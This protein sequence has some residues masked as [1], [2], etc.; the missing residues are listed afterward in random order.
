MNRSSLAALVVALMLGSG[1]AGYLLGRPAD[2]VDT[3]TQT[4]AVPQPAPAAPSQP[5]TPAQP[6]TPTPATPVAAPTQPTPAPAPQTS[7]APV[8]LPQPPAAPDEPFAYRRFALDTSRAEG[9]A[10]LAFNKPLATTNVNY[11]DY[12]TITPE[13]K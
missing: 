10:C 6:A 1:I 12:V 13:V 5:T 2:R 8:P 4:A 11:A 9:E 7:A 3:P